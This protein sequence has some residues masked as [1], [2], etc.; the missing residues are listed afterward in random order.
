MPPATHPWGGGIPFRARLAPFRHLLPNEKYGLRARGPH[1][2][3]TRYPVDGF[4]VKPAAQCAFAPL[5]TVIVPEAV[6]K[7]PARSVADSVTA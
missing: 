3:I 4:A 2:Q 1:P 7:L 5:A 6:A